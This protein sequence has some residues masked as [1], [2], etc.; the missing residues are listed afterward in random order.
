MSGLFSIHCKY[1]NKLLSFL[2]MFLIASLSISTFACGVNH[3]PVLQKIENKTIS[4]ENLLEFTI[5]AEDQDGDNLIFSASNLPS[6]ATFNSLKGIFSWIPKSYGIYTGITFSVS[7]GHNIVSQT[8]SITVTRVIPRLLTSPPE[9]VVPLPIIYYGAHTPEIDALII[10]LRPQYAIINTPHGLWG[11]MSGHSTFTEM[12]AYK[13]AGIKVIGYIT[14]G[15]EGTGSAGNID[16][17][18]YSLEMNQQL[19][20]NMAE[21]DG[22]DGVFIDECSAFPGQTAQ[23]YLKTLTDL[24]HSYGLITWGNV[25][26]AQFDKWFFTQGGFDLMHSNE[27]WNGQDLTTVQRD[28]GYRISVSG[29][30]PGY[31]AQD[32]FDLTAKAWQSGLAYCYICDTG[33]VSIPSWLNDYF[34]LLSKYKP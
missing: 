19:I 5:K 2:V 14:A 23:A 34:F 7:D 10:S 6:D 21:I 22:V 12:A 17:A 33:Y 24:A 11:Q 8:I 18:W 26:Q 30:N 9:N 25:G 32:A 29:F 27:N 31:T 13:S 1:I 28:W 16:P 20:R 3:P 4:Q 15:Y